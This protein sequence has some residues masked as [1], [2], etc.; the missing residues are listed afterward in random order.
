MSNAANSGGL[1][2]E[3]I[4]G[5]A[6][7]NLSSTFQESARIPDPATTSPD[8]A[9][10]AGGHEEAN[11]MGGIGGFGLIKAAMGIGLATA[12]LDSVM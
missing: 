9:Q 7:T 1:N 12:L 3:K 5:M 10:E 11:G 2:T 6:A 4:D 8:D